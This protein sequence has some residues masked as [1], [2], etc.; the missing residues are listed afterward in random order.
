MSGGPA[1]LAAWDS[2]YVIVASAAGALIGLQ[3][4]V[5]T[6]ISARPPPRRSADAGAAFSTPTI[7]HFSLALGLSALLRAPWPK[8][9]CA[10]ASCALVGIGGALYVLLVARRMRRQNVYEPEFEDW[11]FH[12]ALP[13]VA[14]CGLA[15]A[16]AAAFWRARDALFGV[17]AAALLLLFI[18]IHN[19]WDA[20]AWHVLVGPARREERE[21]AGE[22]PE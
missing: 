15:L 18:G 12:L 17:G 14:Y 7:V 21:R 2:F 11:L 20:I 10:A 9:E 8:I 6:L 5:M 4:V 22:R 16:G 19:A 13:L 3:F 1:A